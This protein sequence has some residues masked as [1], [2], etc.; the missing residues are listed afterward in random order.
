[1]T[2]LME[3]CL[4]LQL[5][6]RILEIQVDFYINRLF[7][8]NNLK[9]DSLDTNT[10][11]RNLFIR[12]KTLQSMYRADVLPMRSFHLDRL[13]CRSADIQ[14]SVHTML[15]DLG[16]RFTRCLEEEDTIEFWN[17]FETECSR[18]ISNGS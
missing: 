4:R 7:V 17:V 3:D 10:D 9:E 1:M 8:I 18:I 5:Q 15:R 16:N 12:F 2:E 14:E 6:D 13:K 11:L